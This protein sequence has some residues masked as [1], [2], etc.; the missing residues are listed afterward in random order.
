[1]TTRVQHIL[2]TVVDAFA[3]HNIL[4]HIQDYRHERERLAI[5]ATLGALGY[6]LGP[7]LEKRICELKDAEL[8]EKLKQ[9]AIIAGGTALGGALLGYALGNEMY[10]SRYLRRAGRVPDDLE[11]NI[12][13]ASEHGTAERPSGLMLLASIGWLGYSLLLQEQEHEEQ[14]RQWWGLGAALV[15]HT[16]GPEIIQRI[17]DMIVPPGTQEY[18]ERLYQ[19]GGAVI[20]AALGAGLGIHLGQ[21]NA[22]NMLQKYIMR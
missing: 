10:E 17:K 18:T 3:G 7:S 22:E 9:H 19:R 12:R 13:R 21:D 15:G 6:G 8:T 14:H 20:G 11:K 16:Y 1:M 5:G 4:S 2:T